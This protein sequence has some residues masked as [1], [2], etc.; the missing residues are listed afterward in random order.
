VVAERRRGQKQQ[1]LEM[2]FAEGETEK[3]L[4]CVCLLHVS[5]ASCIHNASVQN[6]DHLGFFIAHFSSIRGN[7]ME[8]KTNENKSARLSFLATTVFIRYKVKSI[9]VIKY[10]WQ[11]NRTWFTAKSLTSDHFYLIFCRF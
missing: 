1:Y 3:F 9:H 8:G 11:K 10:R 4:F 2:E 6:Y 5:L 7:R